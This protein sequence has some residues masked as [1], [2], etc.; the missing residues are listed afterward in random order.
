MAKG[1][2]KNPNVN[3]LYGWKCPHCNSYA[4]FEI[5]VHHLCVMDDDG[6]DDYY[7]D[8]EYDIEDHA[9]CLKC[10]KVATVGYFQEQ[11]NK[12]GRNV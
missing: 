6:V 9:R 2:T 11:S 4:P 8:N 7:G 1:R 3:C 5:Q 12:K 10:G